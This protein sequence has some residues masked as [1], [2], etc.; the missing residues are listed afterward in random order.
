MEMTLVSEG[1]IDRGHLDPKDVFIVDNGKSLF[2]WVGSGASGAEKKNA[3]TYAHV[4]L[5]GIPCV[6]SQSLIVL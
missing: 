3:M 2:V 5:T 4:S 6:H 1:S